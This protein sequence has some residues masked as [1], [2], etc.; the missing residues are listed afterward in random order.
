MAPK[1]NWLSG[2]TSFFTLN[3]YNNNQTLFRFMKTKNNR[4][5]FIK[6]SALIGTGFYIVPRHVIGG[7]GF[8][9]P[10]DQLVVGAIGAGG[11]GGSDINNAYNGGKNRVAALCDVDPAMAKNAIERHEGAAFFHDFRKMLDQQ[12]DLDAVT[13]S[14]PDHTHAIIAHEAMMRNLHVYV[15]KPLTHTIAEA[16]HLTH[17]ARKQQ[18]VTQMGNQGGSSLGVV[19]I[20]EWIDVNAIGDVKKVFIW[21]NRPVWPQGKGAPEANPS[22]KPQGLD[23]DLWLG[24]A[25]NKDYTPG[26]HPFDW[27]GYWEYG[28]GALGDMGC[29]LLDVPYKVLNLGYPT[30]VQCSVANIYSR[31]WTPD[32]VPDGCPVASKVTIDFPSKISGQSGVELE[33]TDGGITPAIPDEISD[34]YSASSSGVM[35]MGSEGIITCTDYGNNPVLFKKGMEPQP[36]DTSVQGNL[37]ALHNAAWTEACKAGFNSDKH[38]ALTSSFDYAGPFTE[39][40]LMGNIAI[41]SH[42]LRKENEAGN[43]EFY[44]RKKL[45]WD[46]ENMR[47]TNFED[48]NQFVTKPYREGWSIPGL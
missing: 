10:S 3:L 7:T 30:G 46:G 31:M 28:T 44:G 29:H 26:L 33:W 4:R 18:V 17:L 14:T 41:R 37:D 24:P 21:T 20:K 5:D 38:L 47:I 42:M 43:M 19:K 32:Y 15:Q 16:R 11:K 6:K 36:F 12:K 23:W 8:T 2:K 27:R 1:N 35:M 13:I 40:V 48:A 45:R 34:Y 9:A 39:T 25:S 22:K